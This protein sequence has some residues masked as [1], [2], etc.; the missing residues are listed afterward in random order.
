MY[1]R[2]LNQLPLGQL[3]VLPSF[4]LHFLLCGTLLQTLAATP[5]SWET[6]AVPPWMVFFG[7][8]TF[9]RALAP[10]AEAGAMTIRTITLSVAW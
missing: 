4:L 9:C 8:V 5:R 2:V 7:G 1:C 3:F 10:V 6:R